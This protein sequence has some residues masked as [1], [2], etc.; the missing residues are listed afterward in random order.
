MDNIKFNTRPN[1]KAIS[2][3]SE[4]RSCCCGMGNIRPNNKAISMLDLSRRAAV[5]EWA[6]SDPI[7]RQ[8]VLDLIPVRHLLILQCDM[9]NVDIFNVIFGEVLGVPMSIGKHRRGRPGKAGVD[10]QGKLGGGYMDAVW[11]ARALA[12]PAGLLTGYL[13]QPGSSLAFFSI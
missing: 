3:G 6:I 12:I 9:Q 5:V 13:I 1:N 10:Y 2:M 8:S 7:T 11:L 4:Q